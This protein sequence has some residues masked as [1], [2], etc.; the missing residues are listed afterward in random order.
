MQVVKA[1]RR[2]ILMLEDDPSVS[3]IFLM[4]LERSGYEVL[5]A[6]DGNQASQLAKD[7]ANSISLMISD[8]RGCVDAARQIRELRPEM[9]VLF[10]SGYPLDILCDLGLLDPRNVAEGGVFFLQKPFTPT[11]LLEQV[12][13]ILDQHSPQLETALSAGGNF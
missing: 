10:F 7:N 2:K 11:I 8:V 12:A 1:M 9:P 4:T 5:V 3:T 6:L 13:Q